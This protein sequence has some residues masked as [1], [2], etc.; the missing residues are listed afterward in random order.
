MSREKAW[1]L[2]G[3]RECDRRESASGALKLCAVDAFATSVC[4]KVNLCLFGRCR[5]GRESEY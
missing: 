5:A 4:A 1:E 2:D 3:N